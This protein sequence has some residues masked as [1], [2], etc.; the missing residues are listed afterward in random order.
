M[1]TYNQYRLLRLLPNDATSAGNTIGMRPSNAGTT[2][3]RLEGKLVR[4]NY[5]KGKR[6]FKLTADGKRELKAAG[7]V[8]KEMR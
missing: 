7:G 6:I 4:S 1:L 2:L 5:Y 8:Y 3:D